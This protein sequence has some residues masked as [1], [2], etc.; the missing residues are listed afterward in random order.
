MNRLQLFAILAAAAL[1]GCS[2]A[3]APGGRLD[4]QLTRIGIMGL[5]W[6]TTVGPGENFT[7]RVRVQNVGDVTIP[8]LPPGRDGALHVN[9][10]YHWR[11]IDHQVVVW[12]G[13][14][15]PLKEDLR[16]GESQEMLVNVT[17]PAASGR[18]LLELDG[19]QNAAFWF[20]GAGSQTAVLNILV[21]AR[22]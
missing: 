16:P 17:A 12:D 11:T 3:T 18:Y 21:R 22:T 20:G 2:Q 9:I 14:L 15:T 19:V 1:L 13:L 7:V 10:A 5:Q 6:P 4:E 8:S